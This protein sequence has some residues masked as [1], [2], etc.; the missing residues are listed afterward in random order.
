MDFYFLTEEERYVSGG[1]DFYNTG[2]RFLRLWT[3]KE[4]AVKALGQSVISHGQL[5]HSLQVPLDK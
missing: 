1:K 4:A 2:L 5:V 3:G